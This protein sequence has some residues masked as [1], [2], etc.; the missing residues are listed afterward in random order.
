MMFT[1]YQIGNI[2]LNISL[3]VYLFRLIPQLIHNAT[4]KRTHHI[5]LTM[6]TLFVI[7]YSCDVVYGIGDGLP[8]QYRLV[9]CSG[10]LMLVIQHIQIG[11]NLIQR[12]DKLLSTFMMITVALSLFIIGLSA[13]FYLYP[14]TRHLA[15]LCGYVAS[16]AWLGHF[17]FQIHY[18]HRIKTTDG[19]SPIYIFT[20]FYDAISDLIVSLLLHW[21]IPN[22][23]SASWAIITHFYWLFQWWTFDKRK[24]TQ[25]SQPP[26]Q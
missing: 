25:H 15:L 18:N 23:L 2:L 3:M 26:T 19:F 22:V 11:Q 21:D 4:K 9:S 16:I 5:S 8:W 13:V 12:R 1:G 17:L 7:G 10:L 20:G 14:H 6:Q 24:P